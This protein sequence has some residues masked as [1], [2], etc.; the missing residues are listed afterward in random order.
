MVRGDTRRYTAS[1]RH[2]GAFAGHLSI[3]LVN[4][5]FRRA[6]AMR[7][8]SAK[9]ITGAAA[10]LALLVAAGGGVAYSVMQSHER[11]KLAAA[12][13]Q[14]DPSKASAYFKT[15]GCSGCHTIE[16]VRDANGRVGPPRQKLRERVF[17]GSRPNTADNLVQWI[18]N[19]RAVNPHTPM[20][21]TGISVSQARDVVAFF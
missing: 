10:A 4:R 21:V 7:T 18:V 13:V 15:F 8:R 20:P 16:G 14:G 5:Q 11:Q 9:F 2:G 3:R 17:V 12:V 6:S 19:P 1:L